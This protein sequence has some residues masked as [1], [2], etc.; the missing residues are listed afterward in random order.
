MG[1][2]TEVKVDSE[3]DEEQRTLKSACHVGPVRDSEGR[4]M[5]AKHDVEWNREGGEMPKRCPVWQRANAQSWAID[6]NKNWNATW[7]LLQ[8]AKEL[9]Q[10]ARLL[11][12]SA[13]S[14][15]VR[16]ETLTSTRSWL[17][18][19]DEFFAPKP[20]DKLPVD[21]PSRPKTPEASEDSEEAFDED[22]DFNGDADP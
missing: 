4:L 10:E 2:Q 7:Y 3:Q 12:A 16:P 20:L 1:S 6:Q 14:D 9:L 15:E 18:R 22:R 17:G 13:V 8:E 19:T 21:D 5:C 11:F